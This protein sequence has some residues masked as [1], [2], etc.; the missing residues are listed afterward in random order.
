M[1]KIIVDDELRAKL[2]GLREDVTL[3]DERGEPFG[4][5]V[6]PDEYRRLLYARA[7]EKHS[8]AEIEQ[9][10]RQSKGRSLSE[11]LKELGAE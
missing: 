8:D 2:N 6:S 3:C 5:V 1:S 10:L 7:R 11:I 4:F 9:L